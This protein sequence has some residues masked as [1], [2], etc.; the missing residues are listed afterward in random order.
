MEPEI[1]VPTDELEGKSRDDLMKL[2]QEACALM[3]Q[4]L[5]QQ[6]L[7]GRQIS[8][9]SNKIDKIQEAS[10]KITAASKETK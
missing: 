10:S 9:L 4:A 1:N 8:L 3:G 5:Y 7:L 2:Y 6:Q